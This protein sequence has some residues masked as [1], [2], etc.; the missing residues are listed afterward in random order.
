M[1]SRLRIFAKEQSPHRIRNKPH[2]F[3]WTALRQYAP[4]RRYALYALGMVVLVSLLA[5]SFTQYGK[6]REAQAQAVSTLTLSAE[7]ASVE[8]AINI[9]V[10][11]NPALQSGSSCRFDLA[12]IDAGNDNH[13]HRDNQI[14]QGESVH[15]LFV[16]I[17]HG[18][19]VRATI[20][21]LQGASCRLGSPSSIVV[22]IA[23]DGSITVTAGTT[24]PIDRPAATATYTPTPTATATPTATNT[25]TATA[26]ATHTATATPTAT[27]TPISTST[28]TPIPTPT[29]TP[30][31]TSTHTPTPTATNTPTPT[32]TATATH[33][34]TATPTATNTP[35]PTSTNTP[36][37]TAT[38]TPTP[39]AAAG[40][41]RRNLD[42]TTPA[43]P[44]F[45]APP[46]PVI[47]ATAEVV[48][49]IATAEAVVEAATAEAVAQT[50]TVTVALTAT[51]EAEE[52]RER[53]ER[54]D[55]T[56]TAQARATA[57]A[58]QVSARRVSAT[59]TP[60]PTPTPAPI[61]TPTPTHTPTPIPTPEA[62]EIP[63]PADTSTP[64]PTLAPTNTPMIVAALT[65]ASTP[66]SDAAELRP[67]N[68]PII[69]DAAPRIRNALNAIVNTPRER[70]TLTVVL[71]VTGLVVLGAFGYLLLRRR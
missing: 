47:T 18:G 16:P 7:R 27:Y 13:G 60:T 22:H 40:S 56:A 59:D 57:Q 31:P 63:A 49:L 12:A 11:I 54:R 48:S 15:S 9:L 20:S 55:V 8:D 44:L 39:T 14:I 68:I 62:T 66:P 35:T 37:P 21:N 3:V 25:P 69:G 53:R 45:V 71:L 36:T 24:T 51:A 70:A 46:A 19:P 17:P 28:H 4:H 38:N 61:D 23:S 43:G 42:A 50:A 6:Q 58:L 67:S 34:A 10:L 52:S 30:I 33:T 5:M 2:N 65:A 29:N 64:A 41:Q 1:H 32:A 26:T